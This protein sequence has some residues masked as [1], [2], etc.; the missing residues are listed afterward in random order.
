MEWCLRRESV[1]NNIFARLK[2]RIFFPFFDTLFSQARNN[3]LER[4]MKVLVAKIVVVDRMER[5]KKR[6]EMMESER[7]CVGR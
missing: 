5:W 4:E 7:K 6:E 3:I 2:R 1:I